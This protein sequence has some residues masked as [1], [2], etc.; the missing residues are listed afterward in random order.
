MTENSYHFAV[1]YGSYRSDRQGIR[2]VKFIQGQLEDRGHK[3]TFVDAKAYNL[4]MLDKMYKEYDEGKAPSPM[5][6]LHDLFTEVDGFVLVSG[7]Y[8]Y[9]V[10]PG[11]KNLMD[12]FLE[13]YYFRPA[14]MVTYS[15]GNVA[16][17]RASMH[18]RDIVGGMGMVP[19]SSS[20]SIPQVQNTLGEDGEDKE[21]KFTKPSKKFIDELVWYAGALKDKKQKSGTPY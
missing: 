15:A 12:H 21:G 4:P 10:L 3:V 8:N 6:Q 2:A 17:Q 11:L 14:G 5:Q 13:E 19:I 18:V 20:V 16:G 7:E 9:S 1:L